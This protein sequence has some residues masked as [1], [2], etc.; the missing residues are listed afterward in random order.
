M[1]PCTHLRNCTGPGEVPGRH[2]KNQ[3]PTVED[4]VVWVRRIHTGLNISRQTV[5]K[6][7]LPQRDYKVTVAE[8][9]LYK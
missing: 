7:L 6:G 9:K 8:P 3:T 5:P 1:S 4:G 2:I